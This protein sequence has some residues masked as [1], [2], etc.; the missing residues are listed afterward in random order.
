MQNGNL[1]PSQNLVAVNS[2]GNS[3]GQQVQTNSQ[4]VTLTNIISP[5]NY[6]GEESVVDWLE[7]YD[8]ISLANNW[9]SDYEKLRRLPAYLEGTARKWYLSYNKSHPDSKWDQV[10]KALR[11]A[12]SHSNNQA[13]TFEQLQRKMI[14]GEKLEDYFYDKLRLCLKYNPEMTKQEQTNIIMNGLTPFLL[15]RVYYLK[16]TTPEELFQQLKLINEGATL[17]NSRTQVAAAI[18]INDINRSRNRNFNRNRDRNNRSID[19][20]TNNFN[21]NMRID[22]RSRSR[23]DRFQNF[24]RNRSKSPSSRY[25]C[26]NCGKAGH[27]ARQC[28]S[29]YKRNRNFYTKPKQVKFQEN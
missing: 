26:Y 4:A 23:P 7:Y 27:F 16:P 6:S 20:L 14:I 15:D 11:E 3:T 28:Y 18:A 21:R 9:N 22:S 29:P 10:S 13:C 8:I 5:K 24:Q 17:A 25:N 1:Y 19:Q 2:I 12:F